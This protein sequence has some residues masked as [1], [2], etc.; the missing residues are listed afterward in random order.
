KGIYIFDLGQNIAGF[1]RVKINGRKTDKIVLRFGE[2]LNDQGNLYTENIRMARATDNYFTKGERDEI[3]EPYFTYHGFRYI[4]LSGYPEEPDQDMITGIVLHSDIPIAGSFECSNEKIN[5]LYENIF[6]SQRANFMDIPTDCPQRD[7]R[8]G[9]T[10]DAVDFIRT[11]SFNMDTTSFY[12]KWLRDLNDVQEEN[13]AYTAIAPKPE[14]GVG[15]LYSGAGG[16]SDSG[17]ITPYSLYKLYGDTLVLKRY[18][19]NMVKFMNYLEENEFKRP[20]NG[21]G[22]WLSVDADTPQE[23]ID[24]AF[25][26]FDTKLMVDI[27]YLLNKTDE[28]ERYKNLYGK[29]KR[30]FMESFVNKDGSLKS[31]TQTAYAI[32]LYF[33]LLDEETAKKSSKFLIE[34]IERRDWHVS[35]GFIGLTYLF[36]VLTKFGR[37]DIVYKLLLNES[38]PSWINMLN[39]GATTM[40]E[41]WDGWKPDKG[42]FDPLMNSFNHTSL[43]VI[44]E[45]FY[46]GIGGIIPEEPGF[47]KIIIKPSVGGG[48]NYARVSYFSIYGKIISEWKIEDDTVSLEVRIPINTSAKLLI[49]KI[50][51]KKNINKPYKAELVNKNGEY[52]IFNIGSG[53][54]NFVYKI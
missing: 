38:F 39:N 53:V 20:G 3:W 29:I 21:Y 51:G 36:P 49:P 18:Y 4:E 42:F 47:K 46:S 2:M 30:K 11:A 52:F 37:S 5:K 48:L 26:A 33:N 6:W 9:W 15:P 54:Y 1:V 44:G 32:S 43:G 19:E 35:S 17:I 8:L 28:A 16:F 45:W 41:R 31:G 14:L 24:A 22:D 34:D 50:A 13:G 10:A 27:S 25:F 12:T 7:E 40:W 23:L